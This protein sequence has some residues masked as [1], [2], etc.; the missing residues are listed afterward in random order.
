MR[1]FFDAL[2]VS[3]TI[4][5]CDVNRAAASKR[6]HRPREAVGG[7]TTNPSPFTQKANEQQ[8]LKI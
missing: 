5:R 8:E 3:M 4:F 2:T 1:R 7:A 6:T